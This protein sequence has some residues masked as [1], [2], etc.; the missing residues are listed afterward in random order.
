MSCLHLEWVLRKVIWAACES[1]VPVNKFSTWMQ[2]HRIWRD[3]LLDFDVLYVRVAYQCWPQTVVSAMGADFLALKIE[4]NVHNAL[5]FRGFGLGADYIISDEAKVRTLKIEEMRRNNAETERRFLSTAASFDETAP[6]SVGLV[7]S[8]AIDWRDYCKREM[9]RPAR[10]K[11]CNHLF[12][13]RNN[14]NGA[15]H[16]HTR[17]AGTIFDWD[18]DDFIGVAYTC[19]NAKKADVP[20]CKV[21]R[22]DAVTQDGLF[23]DGNRNRDWSTAHM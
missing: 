16:H 21:G 5:L 11:Q 19:C 4:E 13:F 1:S 10:C 22:H 8:E 14:T 15:C 18:E 7:E 12:T 20:G 2:V 6:S 3:V 9:E 17:G 23:S